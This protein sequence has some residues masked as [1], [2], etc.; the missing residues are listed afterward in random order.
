[1]SY[2]VLSKHC[3]PK[4]LVINLQVLIGQFFESEGVVKTVVARETKLV[5]R[6]EQTRTIARYSL[7]LSYA[8]PRPQRIMK[9]GNCGLI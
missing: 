6:P 7:E 2:F 1:M 4:P 9:G 8:F 3:L 5:W